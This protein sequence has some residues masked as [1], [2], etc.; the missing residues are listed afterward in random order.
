MEVSLMELTK[1]SSKGNYDLISLFELF[2]LF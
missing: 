1:I 2:N